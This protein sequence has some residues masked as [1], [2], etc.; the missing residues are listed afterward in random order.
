M[1]RA[2]TPARASA[3]DSETTDKN[4]REFK[5]LADE[6]SAEA[7]SDMLLDAGAFSAAIEDADADRPDEQPLY[8]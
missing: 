6:R 1:H 8:G 4:M 7:L 3:K 2:A 5:L